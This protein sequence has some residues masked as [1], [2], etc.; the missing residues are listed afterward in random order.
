V[1]G[2]WT[3]ARLDLAVWRRSPW[4][5]LAAVIPPFGMYVLV[6]VLTLSVTAQPVALVVEDPGPQAQIVS[7]FIQ[8]DS[9]SYQLFV[10][11]R[12]RAQRLLDQQQNLAH[13]QQSRGLRFCEHQRRVARTSSTSAQTRGGSLPPITAQ[14]SGILAG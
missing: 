10:T 1:S 11:D 3:I 12:K 7:R 4:A 14:Q 5:I 13:V 6:K 9:E 8:D 2:I